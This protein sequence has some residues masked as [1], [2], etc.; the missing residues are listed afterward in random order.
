ML[1]IPCYPEPVIIK[2]HAAHVEGGKIKEKQVK[3]AKD[4]VARKLTKP[5]EVDGEIKAPDG[6]PRNNCSSASAC[7]KHHV[8]LRVISEG[9]SDPDY[10]CH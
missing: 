4:T 8:Q 2:G 5:C 1:V 6:H 9:V 3:L 10:A 7:M